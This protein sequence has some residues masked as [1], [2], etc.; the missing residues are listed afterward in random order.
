MGVSFHTVEGFKDFANV[1]IEHDVWIGDRAMVLD[2]VTIAT[3]AI[4]GAGAIVTGDV[5]PYE[6]VVGVPARSI[7][8]R[9]AE[10]HI[11]KL[12]ESR[13]WT[14]EMRSLE[15]MAPLIGSDDVSAFLDALAAT[16]SPPE[17]L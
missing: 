17:A 7:G 5:S 4:V 1:S 8:L 10:R 13:W 2:G 6:V 15:H 12:L 3:G 9:V 16:R 14:L 11:P